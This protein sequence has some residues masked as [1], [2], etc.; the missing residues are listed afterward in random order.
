[1]TASQS[2]PFN[3]S[4]IEVSGAKSCGRIQAGAGAPL[5]SNSPRYSGDLQQMPGR[6]HAHPGDPAWTRRLIA[7]RRSSPRAVFQCR[8]IFRREVQPHHLVQ[9]FR[10]FRGSKAQV[11]GAPRSIVGGRARRGMGKAGSSRVVMTRCNW[12][13]RCST[14]K[15]RASSTALASI[16]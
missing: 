8:E 11:R 9:K 1:M 4:R 14:R 15:E 5:R 7:G 16:T 2:E 6:I 10:G 3:R 13:G 12:G